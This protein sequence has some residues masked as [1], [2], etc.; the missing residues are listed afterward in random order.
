MRQYFLNMNTYHISFA[1]FDALE[2]SKNNDYIRLRKYDPSLEKLGGSEILPDVFNTGLFKTDVTY[3]I[4]VSYYKGN[5]KMTI[6]EKLNATNQTVCRWDASGKSLLKEGRIGL[7][8]MYTRNARYKN[9]K[10]WQLD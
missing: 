7:R 8:H 9:F 5:I 4:E 10:V 2:Y 1:A 3:H 6:T